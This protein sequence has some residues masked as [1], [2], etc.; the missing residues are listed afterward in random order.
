MN[1][2]S[3][4]ITALVALLAVWLGGWLSTRNQDRSWGREHLRQWRDIRLTA[5]SEFLSAY[6]EYVAFTGEPNVKITTAPHPRHPGELM[7]FFDERGTRYKEKFEAT[8]TTARLVSEQPQ[9]EAA[10]M[11]LVRR[12]RRVAAE[13]ATHSVETVPPEAFKELWD[14]Q[15]QSVFVATARLELGLP[16]MPNP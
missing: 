10:L 2:V 11:T 5:Y 14:A 4:A 3:N 8:V 7:P 15:N 1:L 12:A 13:R 9:T 6:R 16:E